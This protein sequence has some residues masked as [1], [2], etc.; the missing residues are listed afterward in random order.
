[1]NYV[2]R[3]QYKNILA[4]DINRPAEQKAKEIN[5]DLDLRI[6]KNET[7]SESTTKQ[8]QKQMYAPKKNK[9]Q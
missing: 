1:M 6:S 4:L 2:V 9:I 7:Q 5:L 3:E 8:E